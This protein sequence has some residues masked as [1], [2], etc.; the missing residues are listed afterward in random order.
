MTCGARADWVQLL[1]SKYKS[2]SDGAWQACG[3]ALSLIHGGPLLESRTF[4][5]LCALFRSGPSVTAASAFL[6]VSFD[7]HSV[8]TRPSLPSMHRGN[9]LIPAS[10][11]RLNPR[12]GLLASSPHDPLRMPARIR[13]SVC[14]CLMRGCGMVRAPAGGGLVRGS[15]IAGDNQERTEAHASK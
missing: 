6:V 11:G 3:A 8:I 2:V 1:M 10:H 13:V 4:N 15:S 9:I 12:A 14:P 5:E 7:H